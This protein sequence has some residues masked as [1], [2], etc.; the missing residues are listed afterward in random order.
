MKTIVILITVL[1][2]SIS[3]ARNDSASN[4]ANCNVKSLTST[5]SGLS[6]ILKMGTAI[7]D[8]KIKEVTKQ[9]C[10]DILS[11]QSNGL[12]V[13]KWKDTMKEYLG[14]SGSDKDFPK[15][16]NS[17]LNKYKNQLKCPQLKITTRIYP[18]QHIFKRLL[19]LSLNETY[20]EYFFNF[21]DGDVDFNAYDIVDGK[22]ETIVDWVDSWIKQGKGDKDELLDVAAILEDEFG[23]KRGSQL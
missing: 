7:S 4:G 19:A 15:Y 1:V 17:F 23:A 12:E 20:E 9:L 21:E 13:P 6:D 14:Y 3:F 8:E 10:Y 22:K 18:S 5:N 2:S 11:A 16:F